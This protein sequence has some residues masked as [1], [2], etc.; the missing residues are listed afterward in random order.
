[1][2]NAGIDSASFSI[3]ITDDQILEHDESFTLSVPLLPVNVIFGEF[4]QATVTI[5]NDDSKYL[6]H[7]NVSI[8]TYIMYIYVYFKY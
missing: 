2:F 6:M 5:L 3:S 4:S 1:M 8:A 7:N